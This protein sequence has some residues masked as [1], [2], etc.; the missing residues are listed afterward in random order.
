MENL[1]IPIYKKI[2][3]DI[4]NSIKEGS[5]QEGELLYG[6]SALASKYNVS[7]ETIRRAIILLEDVDVVK[8]FKGKGI[9]VLS[10]DNSITFLNRNQSID[11]VKQMK[12]EMNSLL[13]KRKALE[14]EILNSLSGIIDYTSRFQEIHTIVPFEFK[15]PDNCIHINKTIAD[16]KFWQNTGA[17]IVGIKREGKVL[18]SPGPYTSINIDDILIVVGEAP[19]TKSVPDFLASK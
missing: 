14:A 11:S 9:V 10:K 12:S 5:I 2:A 13:E 19:I 4:A 7:P 6:R 15:V 8:T 18:L 1:N 16:L 17:T 3:L